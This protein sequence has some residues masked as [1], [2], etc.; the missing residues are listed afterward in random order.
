MFHTKINNNSGIN[1][2]LKVT[3]GDKDITKGYPM[4]FSFT[5]YDWPVFQK[6][7]YSLTEVGYNIGKDFPKHFLPFGTLMKEFEDMYENAH[8]LEVGSFHDISGWSDYTDY[9]IHTK[10]H[11]DDSHMVHAY[12]NFTRYRL[13]KIGKGKVQDLNAHHITKAAR[14]RKEE[15]K[16][17]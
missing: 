8:R 6:K 4:G 16:T 9:M 3:F 12:P 5:E 15:E 13:G 17:I 7:L 2:R 11:A 14:A 1:P 10:K